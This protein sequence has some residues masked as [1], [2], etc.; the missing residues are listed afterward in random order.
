MKKINFL[1]VVT[2]ISLAIVL[3]GCS[4]GKAYGIKAPKLTEMDRGG[5]L[6][7]ACGCPGEGSCTSTFNTGSGTFKCEKT[8]GDPCRA[9]CTDAAVFT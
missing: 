3:S 2:V 9:E 8:E 6:Q 4:T 7:L 1:M 5:T